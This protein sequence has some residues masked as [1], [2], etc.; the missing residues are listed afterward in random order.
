MRRAFVLAGLTW[1]ALSATALAVGPPPSPTRAALRAVVERLGDRD[2]R[3][4]AL[5]GQR[6]LDAGP[7]SLSLLRAALRHRDHEV[8]RQALRLLP[9]LENRVLFAPRLVTLTVRDQP[10]DKVIEALSKASGYQVRHNQFF[11]VGG[12]PNAAPARDRKY[13]YKFVDEPFWDVIDRI[14]RDA[15]LTVQQYWSNEAAVFL[16]PGSGHAPYAGRFG[17]FRYVASNFQLRRTVDLDATTA[18]TESLTFNFQVFAEP[19]LG[20]AHAEPVRLKAAYDDLRHSLLVRRAPF[21][22]HAGATPTLTGMLHSLNMT[23]SVELQRP[24][25]KATR[26][27]LLRGVI[28]VS[29]LVEQKEVALA[30]KILEAKGKKMTLD[31]IEFHIK[32]VTKNNDTLQVSVDATSKT[33]DL[34]SLRHFYYRVTLYDE[35]GGKVSWRSASAHFGSNGAGTSITYNLPGGAKGPQP[36]RFVFLHWETKECAIPFEFRNVP[37]P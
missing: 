16:G 29:L 31:D 13:S 37:L 15:G 25:S 33:R 35:K 5:A 30:E 27:T 12:V 11:F 22:A 10:L 17:P 20:F 4:R 7:T 23:A 6:L 14:C 9:V 24:S 26:M 19:R 18:R 1:V 21:E 36:T 34:N 8:R 2:P 28:P 3:I 32:Q